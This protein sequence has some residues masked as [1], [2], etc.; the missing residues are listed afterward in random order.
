[1]GGVSGAIRRIA[2]GGP[3]RSAA[4]QHSLPHSAWGCV[5][6]G[7]QRA[8]S[9][10]EFERIASE[11]EGGFLVKLENAQARHFPIVTR[12]FNLLF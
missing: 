8:S 5:H 11:R 7:L 9:Y 10:S 6:P 1:M 3:K 4:I 2:R 12:N